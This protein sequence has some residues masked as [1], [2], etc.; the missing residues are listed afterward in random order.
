MCIRDSEHAVMCTSTEKLEPY[1]DGK[2]WVLPYLDNG[3]G[4]LG[5]GVGE[6]KAKS[7]NEVIK[8]Y[9]ERYT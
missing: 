5:G 2:L 9:N 1:L 6:I 3:A 4:G 7:K 8:I